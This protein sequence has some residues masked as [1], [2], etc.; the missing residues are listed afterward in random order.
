M[1]VVKLQNTL[2]RT[3]EPVE[4]SPV[5]IYSCGPTVYNYAHIGNF[6]SYLFADVLNRSL[7]LAGYQVQH[8]MNLTDVDDKTIKGA[9][10]LTKKEPGKY[11]DLKA[12]LGAYTAP[13][14]EAF[15]ADLKTLNVS[16]FDFHPRAT[17]FIPAMLDLVDRLIAKGVAYE[18]DGSVYYRISEKKDYGKLSRVDL[19]KNK[20][21]T[22]YNTDEYDKDDVRDFVLWKAESKD[23]VHW[24]SEHGD[25]RP[26]WHLECSAM[27]HDIFKG[28]IDIHTGGV[29]LI[30]PHHENEIAQSESGYGDGFVKHWVHCEH[31]LVD[32][33]KMSKSAGNFYTLRDLLAQ[34]KRPEVIRYF[35]LSA[36]YSQ[37]VN[38]T[39]EALHQA[40]MGVDKFYGVLQRLSRIQKNGVAH[41][42]FAKTSAEAREKFTAELSDDLNTP[43]ALAVMHEYIRAA[44][45]LID[46]ANENIASADAVEMEKTLR[47][48]DAVL[49]LIDLMPQTGVSADLQKLLDERNAARAAKDFKRADALRDELLKAGYK[50]LDTKTGSHLEK[51]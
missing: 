22:R 16:K 35:L 8:A 42:G 2:T 12:A 44:N 31:L 48:F 20:T 4:G 21:G 19:E 32:N 14:T 46:A 45:A 15:F 3:K 43:R 39:D 11:A 26:G 28:A 37:K 27:I 33:R 13:Y 18:Q 40:E 24:H 10:E 29:D 7:R 23:G 51:I 1:I 17:D 49:G 50:I 6:R 9:I 36:H 30:F 38:Y 47:H 34:G 25:G 5:R 41:A